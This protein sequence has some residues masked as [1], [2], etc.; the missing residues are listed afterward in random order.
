VNLVAVEL[1]PGCLIYAETYGDLLLPHPSAITETRYSQNLQDS[2]AAK[3]V[4]IKVCGHEDRRGSIIAD[5]IVIFRCPSFF[6]FF[7]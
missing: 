5:R 7:L 2:D 6:E 4:A 1:Y 3:L